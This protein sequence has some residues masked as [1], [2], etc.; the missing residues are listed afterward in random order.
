MSLIHVDTNVLIDV[1]EVDNEARFRAQDVFR[2]VVARGDRGALFDP[3][4]VA[5]GTR[6]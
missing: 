1:V 4:A 6:E 2:R 3:D 5:S